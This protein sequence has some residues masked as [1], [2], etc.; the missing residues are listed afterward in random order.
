MIAPIISPSRENNHYADVAVLENVPEGIPTP[1][2]AS[3][4]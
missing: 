2:S 3:K 1:K 4:P